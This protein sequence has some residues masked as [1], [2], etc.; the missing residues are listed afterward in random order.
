MEPT[1]IASTFSIWDGT[2]WVPDTTLK[3]LGPGQVVEE[4]AQ[5]QQPSGLQA[6]S[7][8]SLLQ[9][10]EGHRE[11]SGGAAHN[12]IHLARR[13]APFKSTES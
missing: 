8:R 2:D 5:V 13:G 10:M 11:R 1:S 3:L 4:V 7:F 12:T 9:K 6:R